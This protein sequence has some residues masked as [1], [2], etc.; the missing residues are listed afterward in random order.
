MPTNRVGLVSGGC[1][2]QMGDVN[3]LRDPDTFKQRH[4]LS[5]EGKGFVMAHSR[6]RFVAVFAVLVFVCVGLPAFAQEVVGS[7]SNFDVS[8]T[9]DRPYND[10]ELVLIG[11]DRPRVHSW[12]LPRLGRSAE[13]DATHTIRPRCDDHMADERDPI[14]PGRTEHFGVRL[15][16]QGPIAA[17]GFWSIDG[18]PAKEVTLPWQ[19]WEARDG[20]V[21]DIVQMPRELEAG[22]VRLQREWVTLPEP[23]EL[24]QL[25]WDDVESLVRRFQRTWQSSEPETLGPGERALL[26][27]PA[28]ADD[29]AILVRYTVRSRQ[30]IVSRFV[31]EAVLNW[32][33][34]LPGRSARPPDPDH[35]IGRL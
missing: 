27:I 10:F 8:N 35:G 24:E 26:E 2:T 4:L 19:V 9:D 6:S 30:G 33:L 18:R 12:F 14:E 28:T 31:N 17:R 16:C 7:L 22:R 32:G 3:R 11:E 20:V 34:N 15:T 21:W 29:R 13:A 23:V 5:N 1:I 25:N